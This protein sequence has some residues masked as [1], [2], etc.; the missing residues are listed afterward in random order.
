VPRNHFLDDCEP[1]VREAFE[2]AL[3][4]LRLAGARVTD[5]EVPEA[6]EIDTVFAA[7]VP[8]DVLAFLGRA[9]F[10]AGRGLID[11]VARQRAEAALELPATEYIR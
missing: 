5:I 9:R 6:S 8:A 7:M 1:A 10:L 11:P 3:E 4:R 2:A